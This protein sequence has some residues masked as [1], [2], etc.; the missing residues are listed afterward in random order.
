[1]AIPCV[2][3]M[4]PAERVKELGKQVTRLKSHDKL[5]YDSAQVEIE[6]LES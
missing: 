5:F 1:M 2:S 3:T 6:Q 4:S